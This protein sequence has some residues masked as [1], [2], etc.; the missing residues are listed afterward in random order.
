MPG[1]DGTGGSAGKRARKEVDLELEI[2][3][4]PTLRAYPGWENEPQPWSA[5]TAME[6]VGFSHFDRLWPESSHV[7]HCKSRDAKYGQIQDLEVK[8]RFLT[9][10]RGIS[11]LERWPKNAIPRCVA[12]T[13]Y[14]EHVL[15]MMVDWST[16]RSDKFGHIGDALSAKKPVAIP[17]SPVPD[18]F[19]ENP[20]LVD[21]PGHPLP[22]DREVRRPRW[23]PPPDN[24]MDIALGEAFAAMDVD[25]DA[26]ADAKGAGADEGAGADGGAGA[27]GGSEADSGPGE[28]GGPG[29]D[30]GSGADGAGTTADTAVTGAEGRGTGP[31]RMMTGPEEH[32]TGGGV[33]MTGA[34]DVALAAAQRMILELQ[35]QHA[36][37]VAAYTAR[38]SILESR[39][40]ALGVREEE[41][42]EEARKAHVEKD[43]AKEQARVANV[44]KDAAIVWARNLEAEKEVAIEQARI[45][46]LYAWEVFTAKE[47]LEEELVV[48]RQNP[49]EA[50]NRDL[51]LKV[52]E[53]HYQL[54][55]A[56]Q[57]VADYEATKDM[58]EELEEE[59][60]RL[61][62][63]LSEMLS[64]RKRMRLCT[65]L[66]VARARQYELEFSGIQVEWNRNGR[67]R[68]LMLTSWPDDE[69]MYL[70]S[71]DEEDPPLTLDN[72]SIDWKRVK[73]ADH[74]WD[75]EQVHTYP[76]RL[77]GQKVW[78]NPHPMVSDGSRCIHC[79]GPFGPEGCYQVG[80]CGAQFHP[81]CLIGNMI[82]RRQCPHC[83]SPFHPRLYLQ[84]GLRDY[85]PTHWVYN[86]NDFPFELREY[87]GENVEWSWR[88]NCSKVQLWCENEDGDWTRSAAQIS[89]AANEMYPNKPPDFGLK[90]FFYQTV[91]WH[92]DGDLGVLRR[93]LRP[94]FYASSGLPARTTADLR[95]DEDDMPGRSGPDELEYEER[96]HRNKL[97]VAAIDAILHRVSP[98]TRAWLSGGPRPRR[99]VEL[100]PASRPYRTRGTTQ[101][102]G[103][104]GASSSGALPPRSLL[105]DRPGVHPA[106]P[107]RIGDSDSD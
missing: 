99:R 104:E 3:H 80:S 29:A 35:N 105:G 1:G 55:A 85:M 50:E 40:A 83:R 28:D 74:H 11:N 65:L 38:I 59:N 39:L 54:D 77:V 100:S 15:R 18:W 42:T 19:R 37:D 22:P 73:E 62:S 107:V 91:G 12:S 75:V 4:N 106:L 68:N 56:N 26:E 53:L 16:L 14:A 90:R 96:Y 72:G 5:A 63:Y 82:K 81:Q 24:A 67:M 52:E 79:Q 44:E 45:A 8:W 97:Q 102:I 86:I 10:L 94:P 36:A 69:K 70:D 95:Q 41:A 60:R 30:G 49:W 34:S 88:Y 7:Q 71:W 46:D 57:L 20:R 58:S 76:Y 78:P 9:I 27:S 23:R 48:A 25:V 51:R 93:G 61:K 2:F 89:Y 84:F 17:Y 66:H 47:D 92:W 98:E 6:Y 64:E 21:E 103:A 87:D 33:D 43:A 13:M 32:L 31:D 101:S